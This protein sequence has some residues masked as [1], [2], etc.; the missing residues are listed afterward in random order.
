MQRERLVDLRHI[1]ELTSVGSPAVILG[2]TETLR[3]SL[4]YTLL[5]QVLLSGLQETFISSPFQPSI[6]V[7]TPQ[8][9]P[10]FHKDLFYSDFPNCGSGI[11]LPRKPTK[12]KPKRTVF[13]GE[14]GTVKKQQKLSVPDMTLIN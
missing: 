1:L 4:F 6:P 3:D 13:L 7:T 12:T 5:L 2:N 14:K 8:S 9:I 10:S 11:R